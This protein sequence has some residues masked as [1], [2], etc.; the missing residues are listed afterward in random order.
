M[1]RARSR[2][3]ITLMAIAML[4]LVLLATVSRQPQHRLPMH[5]D[6]E[7]TEELVIDGSR[8][9]LLRHGLTPLAPLPNPT[10]DG[11]QAYAPWPDD[12]V[13]GYIRWEV[14]TD[15]SNPD[16]VWQVRVKKLKDQFIGWP[17]PVRTD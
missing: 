12:P 13:Y 4:V 10:G 5:P 16:P 3:F 1:T 7:L 11:V 17:T 2:I 8:A 9:V 6:D 15:P 14:E